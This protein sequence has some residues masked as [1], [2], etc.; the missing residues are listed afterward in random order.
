MGFLDV[1]VTDH[2]IYTVFQG[3]S[4]KDIER[5]LQQGRHSE[6]GGRNL[7]V[8][9]LEGK[10]VRQYILDRPICGIDVDEKTHTIIATCV[11]SNQ[12]IVKYII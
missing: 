4:F 9:S 11:E 2:Y 10:P 6:Q 1:K 8:F 3:T 12:P 5:T 7:Y